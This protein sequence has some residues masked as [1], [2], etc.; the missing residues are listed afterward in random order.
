MKDHEIRELINVIC[1]E[2]HKNWI[3]S[4]FYGPLRE[5]IAHAV[6]EFFKNRE[7]AGYQN[8]I[9]MNQI[10]RRTTRPIP[11]VS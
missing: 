9:D 11:F 1:D 2:L 5:I 6:I 8:R 7:H 10:P 3:L 4:R